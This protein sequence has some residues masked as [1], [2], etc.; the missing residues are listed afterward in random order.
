VDTIGLRLLMAKRR[1]ELG[2]AQEL[3]PV[4][5]HIQLA[6]TKYA[7]GTSDLSKIEL[8]KLGW[9]EDVMI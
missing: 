3:P 9:L 6:D 8:I 2:P 7:I 1:K 4:P 5:K